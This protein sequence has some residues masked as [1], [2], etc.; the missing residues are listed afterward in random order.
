MKNKSNKSF[1]LE[2]IQI[3]KLALGYAMKVEERLH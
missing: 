2:K 1:Y 3:G